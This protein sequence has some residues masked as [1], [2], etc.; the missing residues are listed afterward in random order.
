MESNNF[1]ETQSQPKNI[2]PDILPVFLLIGVTFFLVIIV[3]G[4]AMLLG[5]ET[6]VFL[7]EIIIILPALLF[8]IIARTP[9]FSVFR[10]QIPTPKIFLS[11][12]LIAIG[13]FVLAD[14]LD[15]LIQAVF[16]MPDMFVKAMEEMLTI[17][18]IT[19]GVVIIFSAVLLAGI[20]EEMLFRGIFQGTLET[21]WNPIGAVLT[22][23][24]VFAVIHMMP[25]TVLQI[26]LLGLVLG[27]LAFKSGSIIPG[28]IVHAGNNLFSIIM[29]NLG[30]EKTKWYASDVY[31][32]P[33]VLFGAVVLVVIGLKAFIQI[34]KYA[35]KSFENQ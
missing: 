19:E 23:A 32:N 11:S 27:Y 31:V 26:L 15:R 12:I 10:I 3:G 21:R 24:V 30:A 20:C 9:I 29:I 33:V 28:A 8:V 17:R 5:S 4:M 13:V 25:W 2:F 1:L 14:Q 22:S 34:K 6:G 7:S 18:T 35:P 16:P